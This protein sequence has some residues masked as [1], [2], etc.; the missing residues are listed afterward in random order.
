VLRKRG[1]YWHYQFEI[2]GVPYWGSTK[3]TVKS[4]AEMFEVLKK[5]EV[6]Q[7]GGN[8]ALR[9]APL[10]REFS[11]QFLEYNL[12]RKLAG[13]LDADTERC[14][15]NGWRLLKTTDVAHMRMDQ[16]G[17]PEADVLAFPGGPSNANQALRTLRRML[18]YGMEVGILRG[19]PRIKMREEHGREGT[20]TREMET[21]L[22]RF[23]NDPL[24]DVL[25]IMLDCGMRPEEVMRM[26]WEHI[27]WDRDRLLVPFGKSMR[28]KRYLALSNRMRA[29][30]RARQTQSEWVF[31]AAITKKGKS[32]SKCGHRVSVTKQFYGAV[33]KTNEEANLRGL[34]QIP[35]SYVI[36]T[37]RHTYATR[38]LDEGG[39]IAALQKL[40]GHH[41]LSTT[42]RYL[43]P[44]LDEAAEI[45]NK[46]N[47][48]TVPLPDIS[49]DI[50]RRD[51]WVN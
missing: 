40:L 49:P 50:V 23:A 6:K 19:V 37:A 7:Q 14:Y 2:D 9:K 18:S 29:H 22:L 11:K 24:S 1:R 20:F 21:L 30:L 33:E 26:R 47:R 4:R 15:R 25:V 31:P 17:A 41:S 16:I 39:N 32:R 36:Y 34:P 28:S 27:Y 45:V 44:E 35:S 10:L 46:R 3:E 43:H 51:A 38:Y 12:K 13:S 42:Q 5:A 8:V 48:K